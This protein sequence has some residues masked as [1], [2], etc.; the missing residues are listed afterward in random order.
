MENQFGRL[1]RYYRKKDAKSQ[2][3]LAFELRDLRGEPINKSR[4]SKWENGQVPKKDIVED[5]EDILR[6]KE[7]ELLDAAGYLRD[8][9]AIREV[10]ANLFT[11]LRL[12]HIQSL[13]E[14]A[15]KLLANEL[16]TVRESDPSS[17][18]GDTGSSDW[19]SCKYWIG[20][21]VKRGVAD[22]KALSQMLSDNWD[23]LSQSRTTSEL[24]CFMYHVN[25]EFDDI[26]KDRL[27]T[28][29]ALYRHLRGFKYL[30]I[31]DPYEFIVKVR[32]S[33]GS[34]AF[35]GTCPICRDWEP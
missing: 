4:I 17:V 11:R 2:E 27:V 29:E 14:I 1:L 22:D 8:G 35:K 28:S 21:T 13:A 9:R 26:P 33:A 6:V 25:A 16:D 15:A 32:K 23:S 24:N 10:K 3:A 31:N 20:Y 7:K 34:L 30:R 18:Q 5:L 19:S 12:E